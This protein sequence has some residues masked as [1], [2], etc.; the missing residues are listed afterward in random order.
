MHKTAASSPALGNR[1]GSVRVLGRDDLAA[2]VAL[3]T[4]SPIENVF[5]ASRIRSAGLDQSGLGCP[6]WG[7]ERDGTLRSL[8][9][10]GSN[11][12][13]VNADADAIET[14]AQAVGRQRT[15]ASIIGPAPAAL[16]LW[17]RLGELWGPA[18]SDIR[19]IRAHQPV[20]A[21]SGEPDIA[22]DPEV[23]RVT[24]EHWDPYYEAA[25][26][27]YTEEVG[28]SPLQGN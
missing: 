24:L 18:W 9:H 12:V 5:V 22:P 26:K 21:I 7:Y 2:A 25:V 14:W 17:R 19:N 20:M 8:F 6:L 4:T 3:L 16:A 10:A 15:C 11:L 1:R 13:P 23:R 28:V 27:M